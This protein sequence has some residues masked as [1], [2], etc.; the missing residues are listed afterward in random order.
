MSVAPSHREKIAYTY[1][2]GNAGGE[3]NCM[4]VEG[5]FDAGCRRYSYRISRPNTDETL[6]AVDWLP[7]GPSPFSVEQAMNAI[8]QFCS[9][10][11]AKVTMPQQP[12]PFIQD[13]LVDVSTF[14]QRS[15]AYGNTML[16]IMA[17]FTDT[18][19]IEV[20]GCGPDVNFAVNEYGDRCREVLSE[21]VNNCEHTNH[22]NIEIHRLTLTGET[23]TTTQKLGGSLIEHEGD[24]GCVIWQI[25]ASTL[26][27]GKKETTH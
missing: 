19:G 17:A 5:S 8:E 21:A 25:W 26:A 9:D 18:M 23:D 27:I 6:C 13:P 12:E 7:R 1:S 22:P 11:L 16:T 2:G 14:P 10:N 4:A 15:Y 20:E 24:Q 3:Q